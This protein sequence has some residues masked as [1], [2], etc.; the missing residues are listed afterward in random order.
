LAV[1]VP[2]RAATLVHGSVALM[3]HIGGDAGKE[4]DLAARV[5]SGNHIDPSLAAL[6]LMQVG[7][8]HQA[9]TFAEL[10]VVGK[11]VCSEAHALLETRVSHPDP[12]GCGPGH[13]AAELSC[14]IYSGPAA[15]ASEEAIRR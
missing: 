5:S 3:T 10:A 11:S 12:T 9:L 6:R 15:D 4:T 13:A 1:S 14:E 7:R 8:L 2:V